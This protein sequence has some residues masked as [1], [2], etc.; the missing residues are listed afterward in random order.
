MSLKVHSFQPGA[1]V[2]FCAVATLLLQVPHRRPS[3]DGPLNFPRFVH[4]TDGQVVATTA[5]SVH[6]FDRLD[7]VTCY[8]WLTLLR[9]IAGDVNDQWGELVP[10]F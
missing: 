5:R 6:R 10:F 1:P 4:P 9:E 7:G 2:F 8:P 3:D